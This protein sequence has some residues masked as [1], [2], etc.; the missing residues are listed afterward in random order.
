MGILSRSKMA[1]IG[2]ISGARTFSGDHGGTQ[3][4]LRRAERPEGWTV[5]RLLDPL[6]YLRAD[7]DRRLLGIDL[8]DF[9]E[10][11]GIMIAEFIAQPK[12]AFGNRSDSAPF[13]V[14]DLEHFRY[15]TLCRS[16]ALSLDCAGILIFNLSPPGFELADRHQC[17]VE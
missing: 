5:V 3:R 11:L 17:A 10:P 14:T 8:F 9:E 13:A 6:Q 16:V 12:P 4:S 2:V 15:E 7:T 1:S